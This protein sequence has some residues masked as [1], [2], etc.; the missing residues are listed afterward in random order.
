MIHRCLVFAGLLTLAGGCGSFGKRRPETTQGLPPEP[1]LCSAQ[2]Q[3]V[4]GRLL[5]SQM[6]TYPDGCL[7]SVDA[8]VQA[9]GPTITI[10]NSTQTFLRTLKCAGVRPVPDPG[11]DFETQRVAIIRGVHAKDANEP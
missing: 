9:E 5:P 4:T 3:G 2:A 11:V 1:T 6:V 10:V 8:L 7:V